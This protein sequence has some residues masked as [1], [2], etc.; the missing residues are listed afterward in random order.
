MNPV[1]GALTGWTQD[2]AA[3]RPMADVFT[4]INEETRL[5]ADN[6][7]ATV[8][9]E[10]CVVGLAN[11]TVLIARDSLEIPIDDSGAPIKDD[12]GTVIGVV[13]VFRDIERTRRRQQDL[14]RR[15]RSGSLRFGRDVGFRPDRKRP[16]LPE[17]LALRPR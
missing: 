10:G 12:A 4:I 1:A 13:M 5:P 8:I 14:I 11:H 2:Q 7:V 15:S 16:T 6:P 3:G 9:R 17:V